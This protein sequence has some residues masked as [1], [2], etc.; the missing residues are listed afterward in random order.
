VGNNFFEELPRRMAS[1][2]DESW[3][4]ALAALSPAAGWTL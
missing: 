3:I 2:D 1:R 4:T